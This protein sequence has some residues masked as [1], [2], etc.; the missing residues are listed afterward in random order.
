MVAKFLPGN[1]LTLLNSGA[2]YFPALITAINEAKR[3]VHL[4][5]YIFE[6]DAT[7]RAVAAAMANAAR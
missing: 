1:R 7:G 5:S 2:E 6:D 3:H 4:E